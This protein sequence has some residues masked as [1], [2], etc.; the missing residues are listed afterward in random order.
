M[1]PSLFHEII[2]GPVKSRRLGNSLG[3]NIIPTNEKI[4]SFDC[5]YCECGWTQ[6][7][8]SN[9][10]IDS[11]TF[12]N[13]LE[14]HLK[15]LKDKNINLDSITFSGNGESTLHPE[16]LSIVKQTISLRD[17]YFSNAKVTKGHPVVQVHQITRFLGP[18]IRIVLADHQGF[19]AAIHPVVKPE[20]DHSCPRDGDVEPLLIRNLVD[21]SRRLQ[22]LQLQVSEH[23]IPRT[24]TVNRYRQGI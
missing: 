10:F 13:I 5:L 3:I 7:F 12:K 2:Y 11:E 15:Q 16:F 21:L 1:G 17:K 20:T 19:T 6:E 22:R 24:D 23:L 14:D 18:E 9:N 4:C 8:T